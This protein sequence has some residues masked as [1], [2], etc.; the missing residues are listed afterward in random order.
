M[1]LISLKFNNGFYTVITLVVSVFASYFVYIITRS[2]IEEFFPFVFMTYFYLY[3]TALG[4]DKIHTY[5]CLI[6]MILS[7]YISSVFIYGMDYWNHIEFSNKALLASV[8]AFAFFPLVAIVNSFIGWCG[9]NLRSSQC[10]THV[11]TKTVFVIS[12]F[13]IFI[14][15][16]P[17]LIS[18]YP[19]ILISDS[20]WQFAQAAGQAELSNHHPVAHTFV[21]YVA[22]RLSM[23]ISGAK[24]DAN[25]AVATYSVIQMLIM[26]AIFSGV[27]AYAHSKKINFI[28]LISALMYFALFPMNSI[29]AIYMTKDVIFSGMVLL[30]TLLLV[31]IVRTDGKWLDRMRNQI[32]Y[33]AVLIMVIMFRSNGI[34]IS[35]GTCVAAVILTQQRK[36]NFLLLLASVFVYIVYVNVLSMGG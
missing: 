3:C 9:K 16:L 4:K 1:N 28:Y 21:I 31:E 12:F 11:K 15:W 34:A 26:S 6:Y 35:A 7:L 32:F 30:L 2:S 25:L 10:L 18:E 24:I 33:L 36:K 5:N 19:G 27:I 14:Y 29:F 13:T 17:V 22:Q 20:T 8:G 23:I